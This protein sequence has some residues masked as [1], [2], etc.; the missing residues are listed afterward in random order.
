[1]QEVVIHWHREDG[2]TYTGGVGADS[3][4][5]TSGPLSCEDGERAIGEL[6][7]A[8]VTAVL[9]STDILALA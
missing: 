5:T 2:V 3:A 6:L 4:P 8:G 9:C 1:M 7:P